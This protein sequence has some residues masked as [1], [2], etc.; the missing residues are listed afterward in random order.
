[1]KYSRENNIPL[2]RSAKSSLATRYKKKMFGKTSWYRNKNNKTT[3]KSKKSNNKKTENNNYLEVKSVV[4]VPHT[5]GSELAKRLRNEESRV[6]SITGYRVKIVERTGTQ[7]RRILCKKN[8]FAGVSCGRE[9]CLVC[10]NEKTAG[11]CRKRNI[12]YMMACTTCKK[13]EAKVSETSAEREEA[14]VTGTEEVETEPGVGESQD[15]AVYVGETYRGAYEKG[16]E[17]LALYQSR[18]EASHMW[19]HHSSKHPGE[20]EISF[21]MKVV[22][23][24]KTSFSRQTHEAVLIEMTDRGHIL[25]SKGGYNR[26]SIPRLSVMVGDREHED[27]AV[28]GSPTLTDNDV[29]IVLTERVRKSGVRERGHSQAPL[30]K[31]RRN[32][33]S[34]ENTHKKKTA[35]NESLE[36]E[37][38]Q[39]QK[40]QFPFPS[41]QK[42]K[43]NK[44]C[45]DKLRPGTRN[46]KVTTRRPPKQINNIKNYFPPRRSD[47]EVRIERSGGG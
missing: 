7:L 8:P 6:S 14:A 35:K 34:D 29:E 12:T 39:Q 19:K 1:M 10:R 22:K 20:E 13:M 33:C 9:K 38:G 42:T 27:R 4:F 40:L 43:I 5:P 25:N 23:Q 24:H 11:T 30:S 44:A 21:N 17:H 32:L 3:K 18:S 28:T 41:F 46:R 37:T 31:R 16:L 47:P 15:S 2:H 45:S 36:V 26:C